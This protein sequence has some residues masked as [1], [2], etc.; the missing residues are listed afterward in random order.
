MTTVKEIF[1]KRCKEF[2]TKRRKELEEIDS[3]LNDF[4]KNA[5][6]KYGDTYDYSLV[7]YKDMDDKICIVCPE[8]GLFWRTMEE[9]LQGKGCP[10]CEE[11]I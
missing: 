5:K 4:L 11:K 1:I 9:H 8:H 6:N 3:R 10:Y 2:E 7:Y